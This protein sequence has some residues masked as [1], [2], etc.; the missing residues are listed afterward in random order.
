MEK[1]LEVALQREREAKD[2]AAKLRV[3]LAD[4]RS[5]VAEHEGCK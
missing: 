2:E 1:Q 5:K 4:L 3:L